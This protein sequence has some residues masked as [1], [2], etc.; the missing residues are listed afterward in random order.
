MAQY[1]FAAKII[2]R[3]RGQSA[4]ASAAYRAGERM[5]DERLGRNFDYRRHL[6]VRYTDVLAPDNAPDWMRDR[7]QLWNAVEKAEKRK[8]SQLARSIDIALPHELNLDQNIELLRGFVQEQFVDKG[9]IA[10]IA[11]HAPGRTGDIRNVHAHIALTTREITGNGFGQK[12]RDWN[13]KS[14]LLEWRKAW[15]DHA[16]HLLEREGFEERIDHRSLIDQGIDREPTTHVGPA[17]KEMEERGAVSDRAQQNRDVQALNDALQ[18]AQ[19]DLA[20][21]EERLAELLRLKA[22]ADHASR[23]WD[24]AGAPANEPLPPH[25][26][27]A[28]SS[29]QPASS[30]GGKAP[31]MPDDLSKEQE[32]SAQQEAERQ[33]QAQEDELARQKQAGDNET[34]RLDEL[35][36]DAERQAQ[37]RKDEDYL[38]EQFIAS[39][40]RLKEL[41]QIWRAAQ[42]HRERL[43]QQAAELD[44]AHAAYERQIEQ[45]AQQ[46]PVEAYIKLQDDDVE[47]HRQNRLYEQERRYVEGDIR[48]P[49]SRYIKNLHNNYDWGDPYQSLAKCAI[50]EYAAFRHEQDTLSAEIANTPDAKLAAVLEVRRKIEGYEYLAL[51]GERIAVQ[52]ELITG[53]TNSAEAVRMRGLVNGKD[54]L[55]ENGNKIGFEDGYKQKAQQLRQEYRDLQAERAEP[56]KE[57]V[58]QPTQQQ[59]DQERPYRP[60]RSRES[61]DLNELIKE[62]DEKQ[63]A[64]QERERL[65]Q[66]EAERKRQLELERKRQQDR[67]RDRER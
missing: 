13:D 17:G 20:R 34:K 36:K 5:D 8:D 59:K 48:N 16:N 55:D 66:T 35:A 7:E 44:A 29:S 56:Q 64:K 63:K 38:Q 60:R 22:V 33:K 65:N 30:S 23:V 58:K 3:S 67:D 41:G 26:P 39:D 11:I 24:G 21:S 54:I 1:H 51:T 9:M 27:S 12:D 37:L 14:E 42:D 6:G 31:S 40:R 52:S 61:R 57:Q 4:V 45:Q 15:A 19:E 49:H 62:Q 46:N 2:Q 50:A 43:I 47:T 10:D 53:R 18:R 32:L 28:H 25:H